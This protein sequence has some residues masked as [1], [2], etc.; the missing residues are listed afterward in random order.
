VKG[1]TSRARAVALE[2]RDDELE[3][4]GHEIDFFGVNYYERHLV[5]AD[6]VVLIALVSMTT[7]PASSSGPA[8][9][10]ALGSSDQ[11][12]ESNAINGIT[13]EMAFYEDN[14]SFT[15]NGAALDPAMPWS[16]G[17]SL[18]P[19]QVL[20]TAG[21]AAVSGGPQTLATGDC[22]GTV[23]VESEATNQD[24]FSVIS[25]Q[26]GHTP[27]FGTTSLAHALTRSRCFRAGRPWPAMLRRTKT[28][29]GTLASSHGEPVPVLLPRRHVLPL[30]HSPGLVE[31]GGEYFELPRRADQLRDTGRRASN[32]CR[33]ECATTRSPSRIRAS[34]SASLSPYF[35][36]EKSGTH[37]THLRRIHTTA[38]TS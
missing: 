9:S 15:S 20:A 34:R 38:P 16:S 4:V 36:T 22:D 30:C 7:N 25:D 23:A 12:A 3:V 33:V 14:V 21:C 6:S 29:V 11:A 28:A 32:R 17:S 5:V 13:N 19:G 26:Q 24:C 2:L 8:P 31:Q 35:S 18:E 37:Q 1:A 27:I 10:S